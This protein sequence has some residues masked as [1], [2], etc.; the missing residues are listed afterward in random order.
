MRI[1]VVGPTYPYKGGGAQHTTELAHRLAAAGHD[2]VIESWRAQYP[3]FLY[4]GRQTIDVPEGTPFPNTL[5]VLDW[6]RPDGWVRCGR[7]LRTADMVVLTVL[8][9]VQVPAYLGILYGLRRAVPVTA[10]CHNVL[11]H[12]R[13]PY[14][15]P[16]MKALLRRVDRVLAHSEQQ[17]ALARE[18]APAPVVVAGLP[19]HLPARSAGG[20]PTVVHNRLLFFGIVRPYK[21]LDL[22]LRAL[23]EGIG[24]T[25]AG[26]FWGCLDQTRALIAEL[27]IGD[28]VE[29]RPGYVPAAEVPELFAKADALVL[30]YRSATASQNVWLAHEHGLPV[31][32]TRVGTLPDNV[33]DGVDGLLVEPGSVAALAEAIRRFYEPGE[34]E[35]LRAGVK[36]V[37]PEPHWAAYVEA[38]LS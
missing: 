36:G 7:R 23:P 31:I 20:G 17:A 11:P 38:L 27:G 14:D 13:K 15:E 26:E 6:R 25:V 8:S 29:L 24:L 28:R 4:P 12:E 35:R 18:L 2:V 22:L 34:P 10:L 30:P 33:T 1:A 5:R 32:A 16:L 19:P 9:P 21:G 37:D 3:S